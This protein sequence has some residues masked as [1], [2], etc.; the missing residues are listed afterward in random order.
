MAILLS[1]EV[2]GYTM[3]ESY[4]FLEGNYKE[5]EKPKVRIR[6]MVRRS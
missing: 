6:K 3:W 2:S 5:G 1:L 4:L